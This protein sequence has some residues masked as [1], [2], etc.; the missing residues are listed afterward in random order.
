M[1]SASIAHHSNLLGFTTQKLAWGGAYGVPFDIGKWYGSDG[2]YIY[3][4]TNPH[5]YYFTL[6]QLRKWNF[7]QKKLKE[8]EKYDF[9]W[10][11]IFHGIGDRGGAPKEKS[12][13]FVENEVNGNKDSNIE[14]YV[15][16]A[17]EIFRDIENKLTDEQKNKF[18]EWKTELVMQNHGVGGYTSRACGKRWNRRCEELGNIAERNSIEAEYFGV[19]D[20]NRPAY[21]GV[22]TCYCASVSR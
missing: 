2:N 18:P 22:E 5:D 3:A 8:N 6:T 11:Y 15:A 19:S 13:A 12:V 9:D 4:N 21:K 10:T 1:G 7:V 17:D 16:E 14:V 20:Y